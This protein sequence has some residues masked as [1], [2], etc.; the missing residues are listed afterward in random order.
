MF[1]L[2]KEGFSALDSSCCKAFRL[3]QED[4]TKE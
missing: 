1:F 4:K 2:L 3:L